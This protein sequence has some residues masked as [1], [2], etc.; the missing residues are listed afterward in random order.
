MTL[1]GIRPVRKPSFMGDVVYESLKEAIIKGEISPGQ[2]LI[3]NQLSMQMDVSRIPIR[4][5]IKKLEKDGLVEKA[6]KRGFI[7]KNISKDDVE[8]TLGIRAQLESYAA[9]LATERM[10]DDIF[11]ILQNNIQ[12][13]RQALESGDVDKLMEHNTQFHEVI[14]K[15]ARSEKLYNLINNFRDLIF[16]YRK[17]L[18]NNPEYARVSLNDH[19]EMLSAMREKD[20]DRVET[21]VKKHI[22]RGKDIIMNELESGRLI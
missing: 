18:L 1:K 19:E 16:R 20:K 17:P 21:L 4:E 12:A 7:V 10:T 13:Y 3:E 11:H 14:Y 22:M 5:A 8:E 2:R 6:D 9:Y 15:A